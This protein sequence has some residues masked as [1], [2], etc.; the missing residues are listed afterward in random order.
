MGDNSKFSTSC[1]L[2]R[3]GYSQ[4]PL[5]R[6]RQM[7]HI[8][9]LNLAGSFKNNLSD[10]SPDNSHRHG[11]NDMDSTS[12]DN[13]VQD[14]WVV[15][16]EISRM[17]FSKPFHDNSFKK[18]FL[19]RS[20]LINKLGKHMNIG[21][22]K[23]IRINETLVPKESEY[24]KKAKERNKKILFKRDIDIYTINQRLED[25][26]F[27]KDIADEIEYINTH[28]KDVIC[29]PVKHLE[30]P[31]KSPYRSPR[32]SP[33]KLRDSQINLPISPYR[34]PR[35]SPQ[36]CRRGSQFTSPISK[37]RYMKNELIP[38]KLMVDQWKDE[39]GENQGEYQRI[40]MNQSLTDGESIKSKASEWRIEKARQKG[41]TTIEYQNQIYDNATNN[42]SRLTNAFE[43]D[44]TQDEKIS[45]Q[46]KKVE[47]FF[48]K[49]KKDNYLKVK[50]YLN[51]NGIDYEI[52]RSSTFDN[53]KKNFPKI[54]HSAS[55]SMN[56]KPL[57]TANLST[58]QDINL[59]NIDP[60]DINIGSSSVLEG[61]QDKSGY[62]I[63]GPLRKRPS[64]IEKDARLPKLTLRKSYTLDENSLASKQYSLRLSNS[65]N[66]K[67]RHSS[68]SNNQPPGIPEVEENDKNSDGLTPSDS[69]VFT[70]TDLNTLDGGSVAG[71]EMEIVNES[72]IDNSSQSGQ[73]L[74]P[75]NSK[76]GEGSRNNSICDEFR[77]SD[78]YNRLIKSTTSRDFQKE[79]NAIMMP[80]NNTNDQPQVIKL[81]DRRLTHTISHFQDRKISNTS[82]MKHSG[83][84]E[85]MEFEDSVVMGK[86]KTKPLIK[87]KVKKTAKQ[88]QLDKLKAFS[89]EV[90]V[91]DRFERDFYSDQGT[92]LPLKLTKFF[93]MNMYC[94]YIY[95]FSTNYHRLLAEILNLG[96]RLIKT[97]ILYDINITT[98]SN[99]WENLINDADHWCGLE[100]LVLAKCSMDDNAVDFLLNS[101]V[102]KKSKLNNLYLNG[103]RYNHYQ[104]RLNFYKTMSTSETKLKYIVFEDLCL[105]EYEIS[106]KFF[107]MLKNMELLKSLYIKN[108]HFNSKALKENFVITLTKLNLLKYFSFTNIKCQN[109]DF[110]L[111]IAGLV[112]TIKEN[113]SQYH[114][115]LSNN[116][117]TLKEL[118]PLFKLMQDE[119]KD[120]K[121]NCIHLNDNCFNEIEIREVLEQYSILEKLEYKFRPE[122]FSNFEFLGL[123]WNEQIYNRLYHDKIR[124][125]DYEISYSKEKDDDDNKSKCVTDLSDIEITQIMNLKMRKKIVL[126]KVSDSVDEIVKTHQNKSP[127]LSPEQ[128]STKICTKMPVVPTKWF[129]FENCCKCS[130]WSKKLIKYDETDEMCVFISTRF[131]QNLLFPLNY[132]F[133]TGKFQTFLTQPPGNHTLKILSLQSLS[134]SD[135]TITLKDRLKQISTRKIFIHP[136]K[137]TIFES[138]PYDW[139]TNPVSTEENNDSL[140]EDCT[141]SSGNEMKFFSD[142]DQLNL[143]KIKDMVTH[144]IS[145]ITEQIHQ[146]E[147]WNPL[148]NTLDKD[149]EKHFIE[150]TITFYP[151]FQYFWRICFSFDLEATYISKETL[152]KAI[153]LTGLI[154]RKFDPTSEQSAFESFLQKDKFYKRTD[155]LLELFIWGLSITDKSQSLQERVRIF[156]YIYVNTWADFQNNEE[157][158]NKKILLSNM[159]DGKAK[160]LDPIIRKCLLSIGVNGQVYYKVFISFFSD[161]LKEHEIDIDLLKFLMVISC[162]IDIDSD[163]ITK[164][165]Y[166]YLNREQFGDIIVKLSTCLIENM[167]R[168]FNVS[169][170][171]CR[172]QNLF[173][174]LQ[175]ISDCMNTVTVFI[176]NKLY[177]IF[178]GIGFR[179]KIPGIFEIL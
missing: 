61:H 161:F 83:A 129:I 95:P 60:S 169:C 26:D 38:V 70:R 147:T 115:D 72:D 10:I 174:F 91:I 112:N 71:N 86:K 55:R 63:R 12:R 172:D 114:I 93:S 171:T 135:S 45:A 84:L 153:E 57:T 142:K 149:T 107:S 154:A 106:T 128:S 88:I 165:K 33:K 96:A 105:T 79:R 97:Q 13:D 155:I 137:K 1:K 25:R 125:L 178:E 103:Q 173:V 67:K 99:F 104:N 8:E 101:I 167:K 64:I 80:I 150:G 111:I 52:R 127:G 41:P 121:L 119:G 65:R 123:Q 48:K 152:I 18:T 126:S 168:K 159:I 102:T 16:N 37:K 132:S 5:T 77:D 162:P 35:K 54:R 133:E 130:R 89:N 143:N 92:L 145:I 140:S 43:G 177:N 146:K 116:N 120:I 44:L 20:R 42:V 139:I 36:R 166:Y 40:E 85:P 14:F 160:E 75:G 24:I 34:S 124:D 94:M 78:I 56:K 11:I 163:K 179:K 87:S 15:N 31:E 138:Q 3:I 22:E 158:F 39:D 164:E 6:S 66:P 151:V 51:Q 157:V 69:K 175:K 29:G 2:Q 74:S 73:G 136:Q 46:D 98:N 23:L 110:S 176:D 50:K 9:K 59:I 81:A 53:Q 27:A 58:N 134:Q 76:K 17:E 47:D 68:R 170:F 100:D 7:A 108:C 141:D 82:Q 21:K 28:H 62:N 122:R 49:S 118:E 113:N 19:K 144:D 117:H 4:K 109:F 156:M 131:Y 90:K 30:S 148:A 32:R